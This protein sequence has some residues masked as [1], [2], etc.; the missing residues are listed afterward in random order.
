VTAVKDAGGEWMLEAGALVLADGGVCC[1]DEFSSIRK[2]DQV[3]HVAFSPHNTSCVLSQCVVSALQATIHE[4]MEQQTLSVAKAGLVCK[5]STKCTVVAATN[6]KI[7]FDKDQ[8]NYIPHSCLSLS[9]CSSLGD[10]PRGPVVLLLTGLTVNT[11]IGSPLL[12]RFDLILVLLD[13]QEDEWDST[14]ASFILDGVRVTHTHAQKRSY[15]VHTGLLAHLF[16]MCVAVCR[17]TDMH[18]LGVGA[19]AA[20]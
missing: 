16:C 8:S 2:H 17:I 3:T 14:V 1:I 13:E 9:L 10:S 19:V 6:P 5:L 20:A 11:A 18:Q 4:A 15:C 12:S 7:K